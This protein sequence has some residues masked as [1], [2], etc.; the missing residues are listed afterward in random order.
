MLHLL[1][2]RDKQRSNSTVAAA[3]GSPVVGRNRKKRYGSAG[4]AAP[5]VS[6][7][8]P[9]LLV[10][11]NHKSAKSSSKHK[12]TKQANENNNNSNGS[13]HHLKRNIL[14]ASD[15]SL[16]KMSHKQSGATVKPPTPRSGSR[17][18]VKVTSPDQVN[19]TIY[20][21]FIGKNSH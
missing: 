10:N 17:E 7:S 1:L 2:H 13:D 18:D 4:D 11:D 15:T 6:V 8:E 20:G 21:V 19:N 14:S 5:T 12:A 16:N 3:C 9:N